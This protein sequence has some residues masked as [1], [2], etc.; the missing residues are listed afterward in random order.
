MNESDRAHL[1]RMRS[2][3]EAM[4]RG[5]GASPPEGVEDEHVDLRAIDRMLDALASAW[6]FELAPELL[7]PPGMSWEP[8]RQELHEHLSEGRK[9]QAVKLYREEVGVGLRES[10]EAIEEIL[11]NM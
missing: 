10:L 1:S 11:A 2:K 3:V 8:W 4:L 5:S 6:G 9:L 7:S